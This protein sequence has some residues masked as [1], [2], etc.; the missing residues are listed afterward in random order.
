MF[1]RLTSVLSLARLEWPVMVIAVA[2]L[3]NFVCHPDWSGHPQG[4]T[5]VFHKRAL[6]FLEEGS[7]RNMGYNEYQPGALWWLVLVG[8]TA[9]VPNIYNSYVTA[10]IVINLALLIGHWRY[11]RRYGPPGAGIVFWAVA[12]A[13]G[14]ILFYR[15]ELI[16]SALV[17]AALHFAFRGKWGLAGWWL[18]LGTAVKLYP[19]VLLPLVLIFAYRERIK[20]GKVIACLLLFTLGIAIPYLSFYMTGGTWE[21]IKRCHVVHGLKPVGAY[22]LWGNA[23]AMNHF[24]RDEP[25]KTES[26]YGMFGLLPDNE[27]LSLTL[28]N[29]F[30]VI[31]VALVYAFILRNRELAVRVGWEMAWFVLLI[32]IVFTKVVHPQYLWWFA[33]FTPMVFWRELVRNMRYIIVGV[34]AALLGLTQILFPLNFVAHIHWFYDMSKDATL[35]YISVLCNLLLIVIAVSGFFG[36]MKVASNNSKDCFRWWGSVFYRAKSKFF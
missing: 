28:I 11:F 31:P 17:I 5:L 1:K 13:M 4:D 2:L 18:G 3:M 14:P 23:I 15:F 22:G 36:L 8:K 30:W 21:G 7:W 9:F 35:F 33:V 25:V 26:N 12:A 19:V 20:W 27:D 34:T 29:W 6:H 10:L 16:V 24:L 32:F